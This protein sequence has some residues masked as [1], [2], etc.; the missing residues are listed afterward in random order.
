[1]VSET[2][3]GLRFRPRARLMDTLGREL[4]SSERVAL[5]ELV[6]NSYD[7]DATCVVVTISGDID[8]SGAIVAESGCI[9]VLDDGHGMD[10]DRMLEAWLEPATVFRRQ[11]RS[12]SGGRRVL[13]EKGVGRFAAAK[14]GD[15]LELASKAADG[16]EVHLELRWRLPRARSWEAAIVS[17]A[18]QA[19]I[20]AS[21]TPQERQ[22]Y[23]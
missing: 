21:P 11:R 22:P 23:R 20:L 19:G 2:R 9:S 10:E 6:K 17:G 16:D 3:R 7:A 12:R 14:L 18:E 8:A 4:I 5:V 1:M 13:G 15:R